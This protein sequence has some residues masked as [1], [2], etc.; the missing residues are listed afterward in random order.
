MQLQRNAA[1]RRDDRREER[2]A[3]LGRQ[4]PRRILDR[5]EVRLERHQLAGALDEV[6]VR[7]HRAKRVRHHGIDLHPGLMPASDD[8]SM[9]RLSLSAS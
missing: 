6:R 7:V 4:Q 2:A 9:L 1:G 8:D 5:D 3:A